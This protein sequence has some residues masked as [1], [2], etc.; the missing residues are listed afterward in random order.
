MQHWVEIGLNQI[1]SKTAT[2][3]VKKGAAK[4]FAKCTG[5]HLC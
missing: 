1:T 4:N 2:G 5:K 3:G